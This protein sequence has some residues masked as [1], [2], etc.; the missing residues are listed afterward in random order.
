[1]ETDQAISPRWFSQKGEEHVYANPWYQKPENRVIHAQRSNA[2]YH[3]NREAVLDKRR[4]K[5]ECELCGGR[6][7]TDHKQ[8]HFRSKKH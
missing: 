7:T 5:H 2:W 8:E 1:M 3:R 4:Q 6:Y